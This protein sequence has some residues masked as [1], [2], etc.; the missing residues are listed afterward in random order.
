[1]TFKYKVFKKGIS[2]FNF[3]LLQALQN[4]KS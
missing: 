2:A 4:Q 3:R 1:M